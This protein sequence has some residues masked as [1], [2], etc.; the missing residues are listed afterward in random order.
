MMFP[1]SVPLFLPI[2]FV[3]IEIICD[4]NT[5]SH[6]RFP[7]VPLDIFF[8]GYCGCLAKNVPLTNEV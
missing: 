6:P 4:V 5:I 8:G 2:N 1:T 7:V 3:L